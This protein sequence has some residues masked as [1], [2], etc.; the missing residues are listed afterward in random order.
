VVADASIV[1]ARGEPDYQSKFL[2]VRYKIV[3][4]RGGKVTDNL[5][6]QAVPLGNYPLLRAPEGEKLKVDLDSGRVSRAP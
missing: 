3:T 2:E 5:N 6:K 4:E 1:P